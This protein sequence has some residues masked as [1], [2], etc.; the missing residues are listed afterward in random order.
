MAEHNA[1]WFKKLGIVSGTFIVLYLLFWG[2]LHISFLFDYSAFQDE[3]IR[4]CVD[5]DIVE[6][7]HAL[8]IERAPRS[9]DFVHGQALQF[10]AKIHDKA[11]VFVVVPLIGRYGRQLSLFMIEK[12]SSVRF[13]G[14]L[15]TSDAR[16]DYHYYGISSATI[17]YYQH[18]IT[19][20]YTNKGML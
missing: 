6:T 11:V 12:N 19:G 14:L 2:I 13:C 18:K 3:I 10:D 5:E 4:I 1:T 15:N 16:K 17:A 9:A 7:K 20:A 8:F